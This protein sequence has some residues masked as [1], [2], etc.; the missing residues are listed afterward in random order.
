MQPFFPFLPHL[1]HFRVVLV[2]GASVGVAADDDD[3]VGAVLVAAAAAVSVSVVRAGLLERVESVLLL[4]L[5]ESMLLL[6]LPLDVAC[7]PLL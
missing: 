3:D 1:L 7:I 6:P 2:A 5:D 4:L